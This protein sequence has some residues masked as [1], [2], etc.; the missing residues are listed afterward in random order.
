MKIGPKY[1]I[2]RR[3]GDRVFSKCQTTKFTISGTMPKSNGKR[4]RGKV[5]EYGQQLIEKQKIRY[6][7]GVSEKQFSNYVNK[8]KTKKNEA[9]PAGSLFLALESRLDNAVFRTGVVNS[10]AF[11]RQIVSH[12]HVLVNGK[13]VTIPSYQVRAGEVISIKENRKSSKIYQDIEE[14][15]KDQTPPAWIVFDP[16]KL[17][18]EV[19]GVPT[20]K[21]GESGLGFR[22]VIE[23][24]S[25]V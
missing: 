24:Y 3:L 12:G 22:T 4:R 2:C 23:F 15:L 9:G 6:T 5:S 20:F 14:R 11:A 13:K 8:S 16:K 17:E 7:Y 21:E 10:R 25:R 19:K 18:A 1:K